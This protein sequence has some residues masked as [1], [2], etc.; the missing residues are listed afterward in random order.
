MKLGLWDDKVKQGWIGSTVYSAN[1]VGTDYSWV[2]VA[3]H[4]TPETGHHVQF[5]AS[6]TALGTD[7]NVD[8]ALMVQS[9][10][11]GIQL[12]DGLYSAKAESGQLSPGWS[13]VPDT[14]ASGGHASKASRGVFTSFQNDV[15]GVPVVPIPGAYDVWYRVRVASAVGASSEM[16]LGLWDDNEA[17]G[18]IGS[19][20]YRANQVGKQY[21]WI[22]VASRIT[23]G[24][25]HHVRFVASFT[26][27]GTDWFVD[28]AVMVASG[29]SSS[30]P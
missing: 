16:K 4:V 21:S 2:R 30:T 13:S 28:Q 6:F 1:Q 20:V 7:W 14:E 19:T 23:P 12:I 24:A 17:Q 22:K 11:A 15:F 10:T 5:V 8:E 25:G 29:S 18:W 26:T 9:A 3:A 27:I